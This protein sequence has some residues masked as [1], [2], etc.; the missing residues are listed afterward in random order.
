MVADASAPVPP[1]S[2]CRRRRPVPG[3]VLVPRADADAH[4]RR[5][6][7]RP[8]R[9][10][11]RPRCRPTPSPSPCWPPASGTFD[12]AAIPVANL[13]NDAKYHGAASVMVHFVTHRT[14][15]TLGSLDSVAVN[16]GPGETLAV[17]ADCTDA[18]DGA[19]SVTATVERR[20]VADATSVPIFADRCGRLLVR[21]MPLRSWLRQRQWDADPVGELAS[22]SRG[23]G[24]R[25]LPQRRRS[26]PRR[27]LRGVRLAVGTTLPVNVP[28]VHQRC[29]RL[30]RARSLHRLVG[31]VRSV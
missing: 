13:K 3:R 27:R 1:F 28:V 9:R 6:R 14:G 10:R 17:T 12:L 8:R 2:A 15:R 25:G 7:R 22:G 19:T 4:A 29:S 5:T 18:C 31:G 21:A 24:V 11:R 23:G 30:V 16:L 20:L 26:D